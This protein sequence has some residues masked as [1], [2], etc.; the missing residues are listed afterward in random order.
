MSPIINRETLIEAIHDSLGRIR[1][2]EID[3][4]MQRGKEIDIT[5]SEIEGVLE[6]H[7]KCVGLFREYF[8]SHPIEEET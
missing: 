3:E 8:D 4:A 2:A 7:D 6:C 5:I 1:D